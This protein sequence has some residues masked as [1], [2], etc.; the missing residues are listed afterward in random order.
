MIPRPQ[1]SPARPVPAEEQQSALNYRRSLGQTIFVVQ[2]IVVVERPLLFRHAR[3]RFT[4]D[5]HE[6][7]CKPFATDPVE[8]FPYGIGD[9][10]GQGLPGG[11][12][13]LLDETFSLVILDVK[14]HGTI[15]RKSVV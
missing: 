15:D 4:A 5:F 1:R 13:Q 8:L 14:T 3:C 12:G 10:A 6:A 7:I 2:P 9:R 11:L